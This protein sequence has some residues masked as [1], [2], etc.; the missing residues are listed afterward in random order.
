MTKVDAM[1]V[2]N[3]TILT[4]ENLKKAYRIACSKYHPDKNPAGL[5]MMK[6]VNVAYDHLKE[7]LALYGDNVE[8]T[9]GTGTDFGDALNTALNAVMNCE[10][11][12]IEVCGNWIWLSGNTRDHKDT[13]KAAGFFWASKKLMWFFRPAEYKSKGRGTA[14]MDEIREKYGSAGVKS[15]HRQAIAA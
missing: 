12:I 10:G 1:N 7:N 5:E 4:L 9:T 2:L 14:S 3:L 8:A 6:A 13:I 11:V 15:Q